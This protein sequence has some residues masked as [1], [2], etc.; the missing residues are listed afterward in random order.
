VTCTGKNLPLGDKSFCDEVADLLKDGTPPSRED[1][2]G[3]W[4][5]GERR[6]GWLRLPRPALNDKRSRTLL[7]FEWQ[8]VRQFDVPS[9]ERVEAAEEF[10][11][12]R[13][14]VRPEGLLT[15]GEYGHFGIVAREPESGRL[16]YGQRPEF[17]S[18]SRRKQCYEGAI[19]VPAQVIPRP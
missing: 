15:V 18:E 3:V 1:E 7:K 17:V 12:I 5:G 9:H 4:P 6:E 14:A 10:T 19:R 13:G 8:W 11:R 2:L 16:D